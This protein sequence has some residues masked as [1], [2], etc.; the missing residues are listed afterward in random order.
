[1]AVDSGVAVDVLVSVNVGIGV[2]V[3][4]LAVGVGLATGV[5]AAKTNRQTSVT[6]FAY[7]LILPPSMPVIGFLKPP[8][9]LRFTCGERSRQVEARVGRWKKP[10][11]LGKKTLQ[12]SIHFTEIL[13]RINSTNIV[14][15]KGDDYDN[16]C[17]SLASFPPACIKFSDPLSQIRASEMIFPGRFKSK[18]KIEA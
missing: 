3:T 12:H 8:N 14:T 7:D 13:R 5:Q 17:L 10:D 2:A 4:V 11:C 18:Q 6:S 16:L 1:V 9:G 15:S